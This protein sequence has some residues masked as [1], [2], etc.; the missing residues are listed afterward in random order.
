MGRGQ[1]G[2]T[3]VTTYTFV[4]N[5]TV[6]S[7][8]WDDPTAWAGG[9]VPNAADA[10]VVFPLATIPSDGSVYTSAVTINASES[11]ITRSVMDLNAYLE[12]NGTLSVSG[13]IDIGANGEIDLTGGSLSFGSLTSTGYDIQGSGQI[14][15]PGTLTN[16]QEIVGSG[17]TITAASLLNPGTLAAETYGGLTIDL[18]GGNAG[19]DFAGGVLTGGVYEV[20]QNAALVLNTGALI[21][22]I[23]A[24]VEVAGNSGDIESVDPTT[25]STLPLRQTLQSVLASGNLVVQG[26]YTLSQAVTDAGTITIQDGALTTPGL[27]ITA[28]GQLTGTG[29]VAGPIQNNG[30]IEA[31]TTNQTDGIP[32]GSTTLLLSGAVT[33]SG[34]LLIAPGDPQVFPYTGAVQSILELAGPD[35]ETVTFGDGTGTLILDSPATFGGTI[36]V[37]PTTTGV[38]GPYFGTIYKTFYNDTVILTG[39]S[40][41]SVTGTSFAAT[42]TGGTLTI[43]EG[44]TQQAL[45]FVGSNL[46]AAS[47]ALSAGPQALSTS[48]PSLSIVVTPA[49]APPTLTG[50]GG[51]TKAIVNTVTPTVGGAATGGATVTLSADGVA[52]GTGTTNYQDGLSTTEPYTGVLSP[53]LGLGF[54]QVFA[55]ATN[56]AGSATSA[57][58]SLD[59]LPAPINGVTTVAAT[60]L[61]TA[62]LL[63]QGYSFQFISSTEAL[64][65]TNGTLSVGPDTTQALVQRLYEGLLGRGGDTA[66][67]EGFN[68]VLVNGG[69]PATVATSILTS[70]EYQSLHGALA[71]QTDTQFVSS[72]YQGFFSRPPA[73]PEL[74]GWLNALAQGTSRRQVA[75]DFAQ[76]TEAKTD[77][78]SATAHVWVPDPQGA[79]VTEL[80]ETGLGRAPDLTS[81]QAW[82]QQLNAGLTPLQLARDI[83]TSAEF[84]AEHAGSSNAAFVTSLYQDGLGRTPSAS[85]LQGWVGQ[86]QAGAGSTNV[87]YAIA[88]SAEA[89]THLLPVI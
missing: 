36:A 8:Y 40:F 9:I 51:G 1:Y 65:L 64:Q 31:E 83:A 3:A 42:A 79:L 44:A 35:T 18:T 20:V 66:G 11:Y 86:L 30:L 41:T 45:T 34:T 4:P 50:P 68:A 26:Q 76:S 71:S 22:A 17:L 67:L 10:D 84:N 15:T 61:D 32:S 19:S 70:A 81:L 60:S 77:W 7:Q 89:G 13:A 23:D 29:V 55:T 25:G 33:G 78:A 39:I 49:P 14:T 85:E 16:T 63:G 75:A 54:Q 6:F 47:F 28:S 80:Y 58:L 82:E 27:T 62:T 73:Q 46:S 5:P 48:P 43:Q 59:V 38:G 88:T 69:S 56:T 74:T 2:G 21:T 37:A 57:P 12:I 24:T 87:L 52:Q 53:G 72:L